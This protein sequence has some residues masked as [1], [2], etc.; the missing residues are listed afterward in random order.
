[1][2]LDSLHDNDIGDAGVIAVAAALKDVP[3]LKT[4]AYGTP[5]M[6]TPGAP[7]STAHPRLTPRWGRQVR[8]TLCRLGCNSIGVDGA[9]AL[10]AALKECPSLQTIEFV[11]SCVRRHHADRTT[12]T[13][14]VRRQ[15]ADNPVPL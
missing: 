1:M 13:D 8:M 7:A 12:R 9:I 11:V 14:P 10:A 2:H 15:G 3:N 5:R 6:H 4:L